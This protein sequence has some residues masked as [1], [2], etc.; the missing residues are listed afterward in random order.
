MST[1]VLHKLSIL[2]RLGRLGYPVHCTAFTQGTDLD[3]PDVVVTSP[4]ELVTHPTFRSADV[5]VFEFGMHYELFDSNA[6]LPETT[7]SVVV[8]HNTTPPDYV[9]SPEARRRC[10][11]ATARRDHLLWA[12]HVACVSE[13]TQDH[14]LDQGFPPGRLSV[15]HLPPACGDRSSRHR[16]PYDR[17]PRPGPV[18]VLFVG[19]FV[20]AKGLHHLLPVMDNLAGRRKGELRFTLVGD[21]RFSDEGVIE[22]ITRLL[23]RHGDDGTVRLASGID[24]DELNELYRS[25]HALVLPSYHE[26]YCVPVVEALWSG[27]FPITYAAGNL[28]NVKRVGSERSCRRATPGP[29]NRHSTTSRRCVRLEMQRD[30]WRCPRHAPE[31]SPRRHGAS[32]AGPPP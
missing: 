11:E 18:H 20:R 5:H 2:E 15:L 19:R 12:D 1:S 24:S 13:L 27:C 14:H 31:T 21:T 32:R 28:P 25:A 3:R 29:W 22:G 23:D 17:G 26:G 6:S 7:R 16:Q 10:A 4:Q 9:E 8:D 30:G